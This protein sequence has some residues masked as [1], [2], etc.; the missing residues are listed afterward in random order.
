[1]LVAANWAGDRA[2][3]GSKIDACQQGG[4]QYTGRPP[5]YLHTPAGPATGR[6]PCLANRLAVV[7]LYRY[8]I[9]TPNSQAPTDKTDEW[10]GGIQRILA[11]PTGT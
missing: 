7:P 11:L 8:Q 6:E 3:T 9:E 2:K 4:K 10:M 5:P 1:M